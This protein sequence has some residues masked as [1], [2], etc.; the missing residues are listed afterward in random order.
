MKIE[1]KSKRT[2]WHQAIFE[3]ETT[4]RG[5]TVSEWGISESEAI[6]KLI[7]NHCLDLGV[8][9]S[10]IPESRQARASA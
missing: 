1:I 6:G 2:T 3:A 7:R 4:I 9:L 8:S 10:L 5:V